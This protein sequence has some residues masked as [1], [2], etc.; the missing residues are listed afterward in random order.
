LAVHINPGSVL[1][2]L[3]IV[4][5]ALLLVDVLATGASRAGLHYPS[6]IERILEVDE[7][8]SLATWFSSTL[9]LTCAVALFA[10]AL[11]R[12]SAAERYV[13]HWFLLSFVFVALSIDEAIEVHEGTIGPVRDAFGL[14]GIF[15]YAWVVPAFIALAVMAPLYVRFLLHLPARFAVLFLVSGAVYVTA[16]GG[17]EMFEGLAAETSGSTGLGAMAL[18][19]LQES[20]EMVGAAL[21]LFSLLA[22]LREVAGLEQLTL[23]AAAASPEVGATLLRPTSRP[24]ATAAL[25]APFPAEPRLPEAVGRPTS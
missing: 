22:Y 9:L 24:G 5:L 12:R 4:I 20:L 13:P 18:Q 21:F 11:C 7:E 1:R 3:V 16:A 23:T 19:R 15:Y 25:P 6:G 17:L 2:L 8:N 14:S 10:V